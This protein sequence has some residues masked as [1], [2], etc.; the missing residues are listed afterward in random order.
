M[1]FQ[2]IKITIL[3]ILPG[4]GLSLLL[5]GCDPDGGGGHQPD[6]A[7]NEARVKL[8]GDVEGQIK[9]S[10]KPTVK[11]VPLGDY[12]LGLQLSWENASNDSMAL[13]IGSKQSSVSTGEIAFVNGELVDSSGPHQLAVGI[14]FYKGISWVSTGNSGTLNLT[15]NSNSRIKGTFN[16]TAMTPLQSPDEKTIKLNGAFNTIKKITN[17]EITL[18]G[19]IQK[20]VNAVTGGK[21]N[22]SDRATSFLLLILPPDSILVPS[23]LLIRIVHEGAL[24][25]GTFKARDAANS[26]PTPYAAVGFR[27]DEFWKSSDK[28]TLV[29]KTSNDEKIA[30]QINNFVL[31]KPSTQKTITINGKFEY[32]R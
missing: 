22:E 17:A 30:G 4:A 23:K 25:K 14:L 2:G 18:Q 6:D 19:A 7:K 15:V 27:Y 28:G 1:R 20:N 11:K 26:P 31:S 21:L 10:G 8:T 5:S 12:G 9:S 16:N 13:I 24:S 32:Y 29:V 3:V